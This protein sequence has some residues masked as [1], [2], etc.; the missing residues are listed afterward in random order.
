MVFCFGL[1]HGL[2][3]ASALGHRPRLLVDPAVVAVRLQRGIESVQLAIIVAVF[4]LLA[5]LRR[6]AP[7]AGLSATGAIATGVC[8]M[9]LV[10]FVARR[11]SEPHFDII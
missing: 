7:L 11:C 5:L 4:P 2:G 1:V 10:W 9:G 8:A 6:R 3:F